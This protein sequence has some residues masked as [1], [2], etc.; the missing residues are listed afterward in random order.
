MSLKPIVVMGCSVAF[1]SVACGGSSAQKGSPDGGMDMAKPTG[2]QGMFTSLGVDTTTSARTYVDQNGATQTL[3]DSYNPL[4][5]GIK[6]LEPLMEIY[7]GGRG[8]SGNPNEVLFD[9]LKNSPTP[10]PLPLDSGGDESWTANTYKTSVA[11]DLDGD[12]IDEIVNIYWLDTG[13]TLNVNVVHCDTSCTGN[14]GN[15]KKT[16]DATLGVQSLMTVPWDLDWFRHSFT[17]ADVDGDG[18]KEIV[19]VN[20]GGVDVCKADATFAF[21][22]TAPVTNAAASHMS[23]ATGRFDNLPTIVNDDVV[24]AWSDGTLGHVS[25][26]DGT[27]NAFSNNA[28]SNPNKPPLNLSIQFLDGNGGLM[29]FSEAFVTAGD[30]DLDGRDE[31]VLTAREQANTRAHDLILLDDAETGYAPFRGFRYPLGEDP[32]EPITSDGIIPIYNTNNALFRPALKVFNKTALA[33]SADTSTT[34]PTLEKA[35]YA[36]PYIFDNLGMILPSKATALPA[37]TDI[38]DGLKPTLMS[39]YETGGGGYNHGPNQVEAGDIDGS[40]Q[41]TIVAFWDEA[42]AASVNENAF[43]VTTLAKVKWDAGSGTWSVWQ[44]FVTTTSGMT[45]VEPSDGNFYGSTLVLANVDH[46]SPTLQYQGKHEE[47]FS[48]PQ[49]LAVLSAAPF[50]TGVNANSSQ[51]SIAFGSGTGVD[52]QSTIGLRTSTSIGYMSPDFFGEASFSWSLTFGFAMDSISDAS[53][54]VDQ[55]ETWTA[56]AEDAVVF[57]VIPFD[58]YYYTIMSSPN[59]AEVGQA[60]TVDVPRTID[61]YKVPVA[62]YN[63]SIVDGPTIGSDV[64][65]HTVGDPSTYPTANTCASAPAGG[66]FGA[67]PYLVDGPSW[68]YASAKALPVGVGTGSVAFAIDYDTSSSSGTSQDISVDFATMADLGGVTFGQSIGF[69]YGYTYTVDTS[70]SYNFSGQVGDLPDATH[71]YKFGFMVHKGM[72]PGTGTTYPAFLVDYWVEG[73][74]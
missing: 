35:I 9:D 6:T 19:A 17:A 32:G 59:P 50:Y 73:L 61:T 22:C 67:L 16:T 36:G 62:L 2:E 58:V 25:V 21:T 53:V 45:P 24:V 14:G 46:D 29:G 15:F 5:V 4:G 52:Q 12:G 68:C 30:F 13:K 48:D 69:H 60:I 10:T 63:A 54:E 51:T 55:T 27:P 70:K 33:S 23:V 39:Y 28:F 57:Q 37:N 71:S 18:K 38:T 44:D 3:P 26:Y 41:D 42:N 11:A 40:G 66:S 7:I 65:T 49:I 1:L 56:G 20:F 34:R 72:L 31:I 64:L 8:V 47:L 43:T 74:Q